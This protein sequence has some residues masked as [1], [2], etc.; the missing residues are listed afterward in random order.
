V[1]QGA[2]AAVAE[3]STAVPVTNWAAHAC[4]ML[5]EKVTPLP[6]TIEQQL[7]NV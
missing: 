3:T 7:L 5:L 1:Q 6:P 4:N 2:V